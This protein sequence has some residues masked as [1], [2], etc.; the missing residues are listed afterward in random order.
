MDFKANPVPTDVDQTLKADVSLTVIKS[1]FK[2]DAVDN[3]MVEATCCED[4]IAWV[5][6]VPGR[7][8]Q[9]RSGRRHAGAVSQ[10]PNALLAVC[11][12]V[13]TWKV[14]ASSPALEALEES[15]QAR[16]FLSREVTAMARG[17]SAI[18]TG[19]GGHPSSIVWAACLL[20]K[21]YLLR[22]EGWCGHRTFVDPCVVCY[23]AAAAC[24]R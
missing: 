16:P 12:L 4:V 6:R 17:V 14:P 20:A 3:K 11:E 23:H 1:A 9:T 18:D 8:Q 19:V 13:A 22:H 7:D 5:L 10:S 21:T 24:C 15:E 2:L